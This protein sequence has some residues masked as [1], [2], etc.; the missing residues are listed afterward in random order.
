MIARIRAHPRAVLGGSVRSGNV[1]VPAAKF[2]PRAKPSSEMGAR[3]SA[4]RRALVS[5]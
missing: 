2:L 4:P 3:R 5:G 1:G